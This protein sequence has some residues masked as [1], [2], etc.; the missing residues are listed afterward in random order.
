[1]V[2]GRA[3]VDRELRARACATRCATAGPTARAS[4]STARSASACAAWRSS[5]SRP[6][7][8]RST[9]R[10]GG[11]CSSS[12]ARSTTTRE[13]RAEL[14]ARGHRFASAQRLRGRRAPLRG[15]RRPTASHRLRGMFAFAIWDGAPRRAPARPRP[16]RQEAALLGAPRRRACAS[17]SE[18]RAILAGPGRC[19]ATSTSRRSTRSSST[20][21]YRTTARLRRARASCH[22][23]RPLRWRPG[24]RPRGRALLA[25]RVRAEARTLAL[26][27]AAERLRASD[28]RGDPAPPRERRPGRGV[29]V[30]RR[31]L[32]R[33]RRRD[34]ADRAG[35]GADLLRRRSPS[36]PLRRGPLRAGGRRAL[37][38][39]ATRSS[40]WARRRGAAAAHRLA[41]RRAVRRPRGAADL[42]AL[43][44]DPPRTSPW[45][46]TATAA[47]SRSRATAATGSSPRHAPG[48]RRLPAGSAGR[49]GVAA[50]SRGR[51]DGKAPAPRAARLARRLALT[52]RRTAT[53]TCSAS[54]TT[55][56]AR[57]STA[58]ELAAAA[59]RRRSARARRGGLGR[60]AGARRVGPADGRR[61]RHL[62][63]PTICWPRST[64]RAWPSRSRSARRCSTTS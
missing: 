13:L 16:G 32:E 34:G 37:R 43:G 46:S 15:A 9:A 35:A 5:T 56:T 6:A 62:P 41:L 50:G 58:G 24:E 25:A 27:E 29:P 42:P 40:R 33:R 12:T 10:T 1:M 49:R 61:P 11:S 19:R 21:T 55:P 38:A 63:A 7:T 31:R 45:R 54:S 52:R 3:P 14:V 22:P 53:P 48:R 17:R 20:S 30:G 18:P 2:G 36:T 59:R 8:S 57:A 60:A 39:R 44:A 64:S 23:A 51:R 47:T 28:P 4:T 26:D